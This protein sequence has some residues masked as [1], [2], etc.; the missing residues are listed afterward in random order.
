[1][2]VLNDTNIRSYV[3]SKAVQVEHALEKLIPDHIAAPYR[4]LFTAA[5]YSLL[6][7]GKRLRPILTLATAESLGA[8]IEKAIHPACALEMVHTYSLIHDDLPSMDNDDFRRGKPSLHRAF[9]EGHAVLTGDFLLTYAFEVLSQAPG[10]S[11]E[12]KLRLIS[13]LSMR[14]GSQGMIGGQVLDLDTVGRQINLDAL[15]LIHRLKTGALLKAA[16]E[17]GGIIANISESQMAQLQHF[18]DQIGLAFQIMDD[19]LDVTASEQKHGKKIASDI[20]N[21]KTTYVS[22]LGLEASRTMAQ[23]LI[24]DSLETLQL[25]PYDMSLLSQLAQVI[26]RG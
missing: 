19:I 26:T 9:P 14:A 11:T 15:K 25:L 16:I 12:Q 3:A 13:T 20:T 7:G 6:G 24:N 18:G 2:P 8:S 23:Q 4:K 1:M 21:N 22:L 17:F 5:R 10:L